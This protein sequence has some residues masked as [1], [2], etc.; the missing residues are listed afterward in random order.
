MSRKLIVTIHLALAAFFA[1]VLIVTGISGGLYLISEKGDVEK[2][3]IYKG[4]ISNFSFE[5]DK[6]ENSIRSFLK[7]QDIQYEF[8]YV[9]VNTNFS[10]TRPTSKPYYSFTLKNNHLI[11]NKHTPNFVASIIEL[12]KGHGPT[13]FKTFQ[14]LM[15][16]GLFL[17]LISG[18]YLGLS[19]PMYRNKTLLISGAGLI[20]FLLLIFM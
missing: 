5:T 7:E 12:H 14:K 10:M 3:L 13:L 2:Q 1:P 16:I 9:R 8:E 17:I 6:R 15:A 19:S 20:S 11:V 18:L 4:E